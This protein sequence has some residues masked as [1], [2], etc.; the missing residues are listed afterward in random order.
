ML[1]RSWLPWPDKEREADEGDE[2]RVGD[3]VAAEHAPRLLEQAEQPFEAQALPGRGRAPR[4]AGDDVD[5]SA[6]SHHE[7]DAEV[8]AVLAEEV[9]LA[10]A[11][12]RDEQDIRAAGAD[13]VAHLASLVIGE[14]AVAC[15][16]HLQPRIP[17]LEPLRRRC[18]STSA[19]RPERRPD[20]PGA[21]RARA[22]PA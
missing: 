15:A 11:A 21:P 22:A 14:I 13:R 18:S 6:D 2:A 4:H 16:G 10:R 5:R 9:F 8:G 12:H 1:G 19:R 20:S 3:R 17:L 7:R